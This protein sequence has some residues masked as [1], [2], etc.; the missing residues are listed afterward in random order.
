MSTSKSSNGNT[1]PYVESDFY[2]GKRKFMRKDFVALIS[3]QSHLWPSTLKKFDRHKT[4]ILDM[5][6]AL[7]STDSL[8]RLESTAVS[9]GPQASDPVE[10]D[11]GL[12]VSVT[13]YH[14][15]SS[16]IVRSG[17][18]RLPIVDTIG[19]NEATRR[20]LTNVMLEALQQS[21]AAISGDHPVR[22]T[23]P[24]VPRSSPGHLIA[25]AFVPKTLNHIDFAPQ[26][27]IVPVNGM[28]YLNVTNSLADPNATVLSVLPPPPAPTI[29]NRNAA[30]AHR[31]CIDILVN[32]LRMKAEQTEGYA[33]FEKDRHRPLQNSEIVLRWNFA[34]KFRDSHVGQ[35]DGV[36]GLIPND[37]AIAEALGYGSTWLLLAQKGTR[38][39]RKY[40]PESANPIADIVDEINTERDTPRG[41]VALAKFL[42]QQEL[43][44]M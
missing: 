22:I 37:K 2:D 21:S 28:L 34:I 16:P 24:D 14:S 13:D 39:L 33:E 3:K 36:S 20:I 32:S 41:I 19:C 44:R 29:V 18:L 38:I 17:V 31:A 25:S 5:K 26:Y 43:D 11:L 10:Y 9:T 7:L 1:R 27:I 8:F 35:I 42:R 4:S 15:H 23:R 30:H 40:G 6:N 12:T